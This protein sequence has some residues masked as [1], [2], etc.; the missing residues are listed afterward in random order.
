MGKHSHDIRGPVAPDDAAAEKLVQSLKPDVRIFMLGWEN[1]WG[2]DQTFVFPRVIAEGKPE[3]LS[4]ETNKKID[5][6]AADWRRVAK[7][8]R[9]LRPDI[10]ISLGNSGMNF[11]TPFLERGF[12]PGVEFDYFG[13]EEGYYSQSPEQ[14]QNALGNVNWWTRAVCEH[15]GFKDVPIY[16]SEAIYQP[17]GPGFSRITERDQAGYY[18]RAYLLGMPYNSI[19][20][21]TAAMIDSSNGYIYSQWGMVGYCNQAPECSPKLSYVTYATLTQQLDGAKYER[22]V[23][24]GSL[25]VY[26]LAFT[27]P[28]GTSVTALWNPIGKRR[29]AARLAGGGP[30]AVFDA[31]N[32]PLAAPVRNGEVALEISDLPI[33]VRGARIEQVVSGS[34]V[35]EALPARKLLGALDNAADW[36]VDTAPDPTMDRPFEQGDWGV[37]K[38]PGQFELALERATPPGVRAAGALKVTQRPGAPGHPYLPRY[39]SLRLQPGREV[40]IPAGTTQLGL[41]VYGNSTN[42]QIKLEFEDADGKRF[43][44]HDYHGDYRCPDARFTDLFDGWRFLQTNGLDERF[45]NGACKM[46]RIVVAMPEKQVYIDDLV[47]TPKPEILLSG[48]YALSGTPAPVTYQ[49]W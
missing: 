29:V 10:K 41:W 3:E 46:L 5:E 15:F 32:R 9:K 49:P 33:Y 38:V 26:A 36:T 31:V 19:Y 24:T 23:D 35:P 28:D 16:H 22:A 40:A 1:G 42:A 2:Y 6:W 44:V 12:T 45:A 21:F 27:L 14:V 39:V 8:I 48:L 43:F 30:V 18:S 34:N 20:G 47:S 7:A 17:T 4:A 13:T 25:S 11:V 37:K